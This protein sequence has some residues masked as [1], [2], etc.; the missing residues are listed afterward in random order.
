MEGRNSPFSSTC[1]LDTFQ[2]ETVKPSDLNTDME[3]ARLVARAKK[4]ASLHVPHKPLVVTNVWDAATAKLAAL[5]PS[6]AAIAT[7]SYAIAASAGVEDDD[8]TPEQNLAALEGIAAVAN[9]QGKPLTADMQSGYGDRLEEAVRAL[10]RLGV[11]GCNLEDK[12]TATGKMYPVEE[13]AGRVRRALAAARDVGVPD[14]VVN[15]RTDVLLAGGTV[16]EAI[17]RGRAYLE[18]GATTVFV[19]GGPKR[20]GMTREEVTKIARALDGRVS[21]KLNLGTQYLTVK[22]LADIGVAR[23]SCGP[24]LWRKA[25][26]AFEQE[27]N[28]ILGS[29]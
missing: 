17:E 19:W 14:F 25:M 28:G 6:C 4:L 16:D 26:R 13:A 9:K 2:S 22:E 8:L 23:I 29:G 3:T 5:H 18:A 10:V 20:G 11:V 27:M 7:A 12:D 21:V 1:F 15:A 24:E